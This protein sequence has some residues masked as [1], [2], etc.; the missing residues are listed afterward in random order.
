MRL[1]L[2]R[3]A[4]A[5]P[6]EP[7]ELRS[8]TPEGRRQARHVAERLAGSDPPPAAVLC[9]P[10]LRARETA[11]PIARALGVEPD[12]DERLAPG[13]TAEDVRAAVAGRG[14]AVVV[15]GHQP[16]FGRIAAELTGA[17]E[18]AF[19]PGGLFEL[20]LP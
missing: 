5:A 18:P 1:Y 6:G 15:V 19:P 11:E 7:D 8:L 12:P 13:A 3:H 16:D 9:S 14:G 4:E 17:A 20:E 2:V 10:L